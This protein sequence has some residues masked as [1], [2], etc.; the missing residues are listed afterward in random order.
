[1]SEKGTLES[2]VTSAGKG[3]AKSPTTFGIQ[4]LAPDGGETT[5]SYHTLVRRYH[6]D[7]RC[8]L[9]LTYPPMTHMKLASCRDLVQICE[10][11]CKTD[12]RDAG[13]SRAWWDGA[14]LG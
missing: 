1:M 4:G 7:V 9:E 14:L 12:K 11:V 6:P 13:C 10:T 3:V 2:C 5:A 8:V